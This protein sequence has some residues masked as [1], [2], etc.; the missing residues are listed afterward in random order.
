MVFFGRQLSIRNSPIIQVYF[1]SQY[2]FALRNYIFINYVLKKVWVAQVATLFNRSISPFVEFRILN[3]KFIPWH[4][5]RD[6]GL[7]K[8]FNDKATSALRKERPNDIFKF[9][10]HR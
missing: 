9:P 1:L 8:K 5:T 7:S 6:Y 3:N 4:I 10:T 2:Y